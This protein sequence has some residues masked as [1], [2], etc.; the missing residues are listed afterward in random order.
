MELKGEVGIIFGHIPPG[1]DCLY[2]W[3]I[4]FRALLNRYQ[5]VV[6][7]SMYGH[8]HRENFGTIRSFD[9]DEPVGVN[10]W[11]GSV[12]TF[13]SADPSFRVFEVDA[14]TL[15][16]VKIHTYVFPIYD[17]EPKWQYSHELSE[18]YQMP[19]LSPSSFNDLSN[20]LKVDEAL[21]QKFTGTE[22]Q[23]DAL[24]T[25]CDETCRLG[26]YCQ[27]RNSNHFDQKD[28]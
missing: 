23:Q 18:L 10:V 8:V 7:L 2:E 11:T 3:S 19:D 28:C 16:P 14:E 5:H 22:N 13:S 24:A 27:T 15:V 25:S 20:R 21:A 1:D 9:T 17:A 4:R 26:L 12:T 6:R